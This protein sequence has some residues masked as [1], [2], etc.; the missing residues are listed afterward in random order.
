MTSVLFVT[1]FKDINRGNWGSYTRSRETYISWFKLLIRNRIHL[2]VFADDSTLRIIKDECG[3]PH[4]FPYDE[5][6][7]YF[8]KIFKHYDILNSDF[9]TQ[10]RKITRVRPEIVYPEY[11]I[12]NYNKLIFIKRARAMAPTYTHY[13]WIDFGHCRTEQDVYSNFDWEKLPLDRIV[14]GSTNECVKPLSPVD[15]LLKDTYLTFM[16]GGMF[17]I[18]TSMVDWF[19]DAFDSEIKLYESAGILDNDQNLFKQIYYKNPSKF[20]L[21]PGDWFELLRHYSI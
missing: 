4:V 1:A 12:V 11:N 3:Y 17:V 16:K 8:T 6:N 21:V 19:H 18:P 20:H 15:A 5:M 13:A 7:T 2:V 14:F 10:M 9:M